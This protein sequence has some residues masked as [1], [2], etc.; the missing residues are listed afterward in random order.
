M[1]E[2]QI[3]DWEMRERRAHAEMLKDIQAVLATKS[4]RSFIKYL[5]REFEVGELPPIGLEGNILMDKLGFL[6]AGNSVFKM[7][8]E[9]NHEAAGQILGQIEKEKYEIIL[10]DAVQRKG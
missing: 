9:A 10:Q 8:A 5:F 3:S 7:V 2:N 6:R 1:T 4:G